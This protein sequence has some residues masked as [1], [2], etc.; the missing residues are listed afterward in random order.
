MLNEP[1]ASSHTKKRTQSSTA[2]QVNSMGRVDIQVET[3]R[4]EHE[5]HDRQSVVL[6]LHYG[7]HKPDFSRATTWW[8]TY[9]K[10]SEPHETHAVKMHRPFLHETAD[11]PRRHRISSHGKLNDC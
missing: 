11:I 4:V 8:R 1:T 6:E 10:D 3:I 9:W 5:L 2:L 7:R